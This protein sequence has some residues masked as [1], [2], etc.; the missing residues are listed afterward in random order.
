[1]NFIG[2]EIAM[3][4]QKI[5]KIICDEENEISTKCNIGVNLH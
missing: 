4:E 5:I 1:M 3:S 2:N